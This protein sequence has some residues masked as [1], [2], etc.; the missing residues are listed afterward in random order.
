MGGGCGPRSP[1][2]LEVG[3]PYRYFQD[4]GEEGGE[5][6]WGEVMDRSADA[7]AGNG[8]SET[9]SGKRILYCMSCLG[10]KTVEI[11]LGS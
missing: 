11:M 10:D 6:T 1:G 5:R 9:E 4:L 8:S 3:I 2:F 7:R